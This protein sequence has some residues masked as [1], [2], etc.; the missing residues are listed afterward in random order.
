MSAAALVAALL[1]LGIPVA[2][3]VALRAV[4]PLLP[5][6]GALYLFFAFVWLPR[7]CRSVVHGVRGRT[8]YVRC[9]VWLR[10]DTAVRLDRVT[11]ITE[12]TG[13]FE[14]RCGVTALLVCIPGTFFLVPAVTQ[15][16]AAQYRALWEGKGA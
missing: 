1:L 11:Q 6:P 13:P 2:A 4:L 8:L 12:L 5:L 9:G 16:E 15:A 14:R 7:F 10:R 3:G